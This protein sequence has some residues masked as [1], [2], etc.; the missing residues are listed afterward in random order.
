MELRTDRPRERARTLCEFNKRSPRNMHADGGMGGGTGSGTNVQD[1]HEMECRLAY[2]QSQVESAQ[3]APTPVPTVVSE[4]E[5]T[6]RH[7]TMGLSIT[8][9]MPPPGASAA[10]PAHPAALQATNRTLSGRP[11]WFT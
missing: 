6:F 1:W 7:C 5:V 4:F 10:L 2:M 8:R 3:S 9:A 11:A